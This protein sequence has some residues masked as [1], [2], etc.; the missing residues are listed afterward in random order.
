M[1]DYEKLARER[2]PVAAAAGRI[3]GTPGPLLL[4][5]CRDTVSRRVVM[6]D[7]PSK[8]YR[9]Q[10]K[11][12]D[13]GCGHPCCSSDHRTID[14]EIPDARTKTTTAKPTVNTAG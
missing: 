9:R 14:L 3:F 11:W 12:L 2:C 7:S 5:S 10:Q 4:L 8:L 6:F 13:E 1:P